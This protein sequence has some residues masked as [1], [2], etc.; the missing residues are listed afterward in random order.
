MEFNILKKYIK[1]TKIFKFIFKFLVKQV[2]KKHVED[3][4]Q[5]FVGPSILSPDL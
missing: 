4:N 2:F 3:N 5:I 1:I